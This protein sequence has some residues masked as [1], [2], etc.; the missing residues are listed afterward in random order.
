MKHLPGISVIVLMC[1]V[2]V[3]CD[4]RKEQPF[5][6]LSAIEG[7]WS[8][9]GDTPESGELIES[10]TRVNDTL[11][12][13]K[14]YQ[15]EKGDTSFLETLE[16]VATGNS[17]FYIPT[18]FNQ[19]DQKPVSFRL[20]TK[21]KNKYTFEN[22]QHDFPTTIIYDFKNDSTLNASVSGTIRG[23]VRVMEFFYTKK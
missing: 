23:E 16:L 21:D 6:G 7:T 19:N 14:S 9:S 10:W 22:P 20:T 8:M 17:I 13:G 11:F 18:V 15:V 12:A 5:G 1:L 3:S 2:I 4:T